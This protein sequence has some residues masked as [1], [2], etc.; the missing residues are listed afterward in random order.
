MLKILY[1]RNRSWP[2]KIPRAIDGNDKLL[3]KVYFRPDAWAA[4]TVYEKTDEW[5]DVV[6]PT[7]FKGLYFRI[8]YPGKSG[9]TD[10]FTGTYAEGDEVTDGTATWE[11]VEYDLLET[12]VTVSTCDFTA[13]DSVTL[14]SESAAT[15]TAQCLISTIPASVTEFDV[16]GHPILSNSEEFDMTFT[17]KV[18]AR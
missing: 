4:T 17:F 14:A 16:T 13:T 7:T 5:A 2:Y 18:K 10:P 9:S 1:E 6:M 15:T 3:L 11:A 12:G 8:K